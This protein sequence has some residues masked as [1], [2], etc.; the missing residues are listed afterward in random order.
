[1]NPLTRP[2]IYLG[3][4]FATVLPV[5]T[6]PVIANSVQAQTAKTTLYVDPSAGNDQTARGTRDQPYST[7]TAA[8][9][10]APSQAVIQLADGTYSEETGE[11][12]PIIVRKPVEIRGDPDNQGYNVKIEGGGEFNSRTGAGQNVAIALLGNS[13]L[14]GVS[15]TNPRDRGIGIWIEGASPTVLKNTLQRNDNTGIA[16]NGRGRAVILDNYFYNNSG[17]GMVIYGQSRPTV[18]NNTFERTGF[19]ISITEDASPQLIGNDIK[20]NRIGVIVEGNAQPILR[21]NVITLSSE[22]GLVAIANSQPN[23]GTANEPGGNIFRSNRG[24]AIKNLTKSYTIPAS[25]NQIS[26]DTAGKVDVRAT[27][28][29]TQTAPISLN[30]NISP[31]SPLSSKENALR[32]SSSDDEQVW[33]APN[34]TPLPPLNSLPLLPS[35]PKNNVEERNSLPFDPPPLE[36]LPN[37]NAATGNDQAADP[38][39]NGTRL[40]DILVLEPNVSP[41]S[42]SRRNTNSLP[43]PS[44]NIPSGRPFRPGASPEERVTAVGGQYRVVVEITKASD[45]SQVKQIVPEAFTSRYQGRAVMQVGIF[46][47]QANVEEIRQQLRQAGLQVRVITVG[48]DR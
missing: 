20:S 12:F 3:L 1:V 40:Q 43:V 5:L 30:R 18:K 23:L 32:S 39:S 4:A 28:A 41:N 15:V 33:S 47:S 35:T 19:G 7:L 36:P 27:V 11:N 2:S 21:E 42:S 24:Q 46:R 10:A 38:P 34:S 22:D 16:L 9:A 37:N 48:N 8:I 6:A 31:L 13:T 25:G 44:A 29:Q 14:T 45:K 17:N 26:G